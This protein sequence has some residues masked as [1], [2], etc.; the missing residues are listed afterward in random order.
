M[1]PQFRL[2]PRTPTAPVAVGP[3]PPSVGTSARAHCLLPA[4]IRA[5]VRPPGNHLMSVPVDGELS[6]ITQ[7]GDQ[8]GGEPD[9]TWRPFDG[10]DGRMCSGI[11]STTLPA[12]R[13]HERTSAAMGHSGAVRSRIGLVLDDPRARCTTRKAPAVLIIQ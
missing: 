3:K 11:T 12:Y 4:L 10:Q 13:D 2:L 9:A 7:R 1:R 8:L 5:D 6:R